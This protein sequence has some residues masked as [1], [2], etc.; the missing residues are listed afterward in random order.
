MSPAGLDERV[1]EQGKVVE[2]MFYRKRTEKDTPWHRGG[3]P[4]EED[5]TFREAFVAAGMDFEIEKRPNLV[6]LNR[7]P[8]K[9]EDYVPPI[10]DPV[11][12][13]SW[14]ITTGESFSIVRTDIEE[15]IGTVGRAYGLLQN[16]EAMEPLEP[17]VDQGYMTLETGGCLKGGRD[18]WMMVRFNVDEILR[19]CDPEAQ[20]TLA[21]LMHDSPQNR[22]VP[23]GLLTWNHSG[24]GK[25]R[26]KATL[27][28][29]VCA[30]TLE[31]AVSERSEF[32][33]AVKHSKN[34]K[35]NWKVSADALMRYLV[36]QY[37]DFGKAQAMLEARYLTNT[38]FTRAV[39][40]PIVPIRHLE[41]KVYQREATAKTHAA[42]ERAQGRRNRIRELWMEGTGVS[43]EP[44]AWDAYNGACEFLDHD[45]LAFAKG[46][47]SPERRIEPMVK[48]II[49]NNKRRVLGNLIALNP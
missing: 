12:D 3:T 31:I 28:R 17:L 39:Q 42:L 11:F 49:R 32:E 7:N 14:Y 43:G 34:V 41:I 44:T 20:D 48:G 21:W 22:V 24:V 33:I 37:V 29:V 46:D 35:Q 19:R 4:F 25:P 13:E 15:V 36:G 40:D 45:N 30:N 27:V 47:P 18:L 1:N 26:C 38:E 2:T 10:G 8:K 16:R 9:G 5:A 23:Y 6:Q